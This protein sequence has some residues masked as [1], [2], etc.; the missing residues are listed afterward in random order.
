[1]K[2][3]LNLHLTYAH[4]SPD[5]KKSGIIA[6]EHRKTPKGPRSKKSPRRQHLSGTIQGDTL[7]EDEDEDVHSPSVLQCA[8]GLFDKA[9]LGL[10]PL[11]DPKSFLVEALFGAQVGHFV[12]FSE[13]HPTPLDCAP[14]LTVLHVFFRRPFLARRPTVHIFGSVCGGIGLDQ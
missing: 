3:T 4:R 11:F 14:I 1:M 10:H 7:W 6:E 12:S 9:R 2:T 5:L 13:L 8:L